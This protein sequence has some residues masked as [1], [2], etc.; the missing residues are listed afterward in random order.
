MELADLN[1]LTYVIKFRGGRYFMNRVGRVAGVCGS[2]QDWSRPYS[3]DNLAEASIYN[4]P[5]EARKI[6]KQFTKNR[7]EN[8]TVHP[9]SKKIFF[10]A[11]LKGDR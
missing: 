11:T 3:T 6:C 1:L 5:K 7:A 10:E 2:I 8:A 9:V 4:D